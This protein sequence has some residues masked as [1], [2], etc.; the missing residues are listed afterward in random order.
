MHST[1]IFTV[2]SSEQAN[3]WQRM[4]MW[5]FEAFGTCAGRCFKFSPFSCGRTQLHLHFQEVR[6]YCLL[7]C[8]LQSPMSARDLGQLTKQW[9]IKIFTELSTCELSCF[10]QIGDHDGCV[11]SDQ[12]VRCRPQHHSI[13]RKLGRPSWGSLCFSRCIGGGVGANNWFCQRK[14][15]VF[16]W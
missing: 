1:V 4:S 12:A 5:K 6:W 2:Q 13:L 7:H 11:L 14:G 3:H 10:I 9:L 16:V 8:G 15:G